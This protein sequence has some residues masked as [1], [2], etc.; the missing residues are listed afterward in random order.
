MEAEGSRAFRK[1]SAIAK[2]RPVDRFARHAA[3]P[4]Q[5]CGHV[6]ESRVP[7]LESDLVAFIEGAFPSVWALETLMLLR[8]E[9]GKPW[10]AQRLVAELRASGPLVDDCLA[11]LI[12]VGLVVGADEAFRYA[13]ANA[14][15]QALCDALDAAY[16]ERPVAV[17]NAI[18]TRRPDALKGFADSFRL[19]GWKS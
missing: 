12:Q 6:N 18:A 8:A 1:K 3:Q 16:R 15:L 5:R 14:R 4:S 13:P 10:T 17:T 19:G 9:P 2:R 11:R 7:A